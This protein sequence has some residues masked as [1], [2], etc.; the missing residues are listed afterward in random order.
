MTGVLILIKVKRGWSLTV[1]CSVMLSVSMVEQ[2][3]N[4]AFREW[5]A[6][7]FCVLGEKKM[8]TVGLVYYK[9]QIVCACVSLITA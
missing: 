1:S 4:L 9:G 2:Q 3:G 6:N 7:S 5:C 8:L